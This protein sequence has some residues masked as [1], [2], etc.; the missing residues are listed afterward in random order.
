MP[1]A[2]T[3]GA[4]TAMAVAS[5]SDNNCGLHAMNNQPANET[6]FVINAVEHSELINAIPNPASEKTTIVYKLSSEVINAEIKIT[7]LLGEV[8]AKYPVT[9]GTNSLEVYCSGFTSGIYFYSL[10]KNT[11]LVKTK[12]MIISK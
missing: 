9:S 8:I 12:K 10:S 5:Q 7:N 6:G 3:S 1:G 2:N 11:N 4:L